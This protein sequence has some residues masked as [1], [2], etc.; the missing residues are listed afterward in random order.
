MNSYA[1]GSEYYNIDECKMKVK[2]YIKLKP[3]LKDFKLELNKVVSYL[4]DKDPCIPPNELFIY[5]YKCNLEDIIQFPCKMKI[6][7]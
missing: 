4:N 7:Y 2:E 1:M 5:V 6:A 3:I